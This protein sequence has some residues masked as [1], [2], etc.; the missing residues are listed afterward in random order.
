MCYIYTMEYYSDTERDE[1]LIHDTMYMNLENMVKTSCE[2][3]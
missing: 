3:G 1:V 2:V